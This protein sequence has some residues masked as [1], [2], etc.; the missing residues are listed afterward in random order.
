MLRVPASCAALQ[1]LPF[2]DATAEAETKEDAGGEVTVERGAKSVKRQQAR[3]QRRPLKQ[4]I[5]MLSQSGG[6]SLAIGMRG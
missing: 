6:L 2:A 3:W 5:S 4:L 1:R